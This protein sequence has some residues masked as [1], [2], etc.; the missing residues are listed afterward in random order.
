MHKKGKKKVK[1]GVKN[2]TVYMCFNDAHAFLLKFYG[3]SKKVS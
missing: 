2:K 3:V 1:T